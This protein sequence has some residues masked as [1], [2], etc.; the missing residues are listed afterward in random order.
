MLFVIRRGPNDVP[1][2]LSTQFGDV[3]GGKDAIGDIRLAPYDVVYVPRT[4]VA[5]EAGLAVDDGVLL[6]ESRSAADG[7]FA[8]GDVARVP[9]PLADG[10]RIHPQYRDEFETGVAVAWH[11]VP[12]THGCFGNWSDGARRTHYRNLCG[13]D[14]RVVLAGEHASLLPAW[15]EGA[16]L[17]SLDAVTRLHGRI[18]A[19]A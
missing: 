16:V 9:H 5:E 4:G 2:F 17:S 7:I 10:A 18:T 14:G 19:K 3:I 6:D 15:Q 12:W 11:R 8:A 13:I 1:Q